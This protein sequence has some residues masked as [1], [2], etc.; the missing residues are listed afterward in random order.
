[1]N[2]LLVEPEYRRLTTSKRK[3]LAA[4]RTGAIAEAK[5][6]R[7]DETLWYPPL[8]LLKLARFHRQRGDN[9]EFAIGCDPTF[10][11]NAT[12]FSQTHL[13]DRVYITTL[14]TYDFAKI[15]RTISYYRDAVGGTTGKVFVG[16][17]MATLMADALFEQT[18][19]YPIPGVLR[20]ASQ[21]RLKGHTDIDLLPPDYSILSPEL[22]AIN[23]T[24]Y[25]YTS[26]GCT[27]SCPWC[28][29]PR[30]EPEFIPYIDIKPT[31][32]ALR[33]EYGDKGRLKLMDNNVLASPELGRIVTDLVELGYGKGSYTRTQPPRQRVVDFNQGVDATYMSEEVMKLL[34]RIN[35]APMRIAFDRGAEKK[36]YV[37]A[38]EIAHKH[39]CTDFSSYMLY[40]YQDSPRDLYDRLMVNVELNEQ[41]VQ[42]GQRA[43]RGQIYSYPM[44]YAPIDESCGVRANQRRDFVAPV[45]ARQRNWLKNPAWTKRFVRNIEIMKG[46]VHGAISSTPSL[47]R[48]TIG[49]SFEEFL[50]NLYMPEEMLRN[51]NKHEKRIY[52]GEPKRRPGN[53]NVEDFRAFI[54]RL[55]RRQKDEFW[56]FHEAVSENTV[57]A[58]RGYLACC[59]DKGTRR[60]LRFYLRK[61]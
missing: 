13:W 51:R 19:V 3:L 4:H 59:K 8:G 24:Y 1:M 53:G 20:S 27:N 39:G 15:V 12:L 45:S 48:R 50:A 7:D 30:L 52:D 56:Q 28:G 5:A 46:A 22:Y 25:A 61:R 57:E 60:W 32:L 38:V 9:V 49:L 18:G 41:W 21:L 43:R 14:F 31:I 2:I 34:A 40:N 37:A 47:A 42:D 55:L 44:R 10:V 58:I 33:K 23:D 29:V 16:G 54:L 36:Q 35:I 26:R 11:P 6:S 17:I